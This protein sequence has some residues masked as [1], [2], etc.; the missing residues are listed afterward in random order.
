METLCKCGYAKEVCLNVEE[1]H[2]KFASRGTKGVNK[3]DLQKPKS[4]GPKRRAKQKKIP[5]HLRALHQ[6]IKQE[7]KVPGESQ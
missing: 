4:Y 2:C 1:D 6:M 5:K 7:S 3:S